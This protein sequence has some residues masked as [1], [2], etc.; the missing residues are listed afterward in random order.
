M[1]RTVLSRCALAVLLAVVGAAPLLL[2]LACVDERAVL[3]G[4]L[5]GGF[6]LA[7]A[8]LAADRFAC[9]EPRALLAQPGYLLGA[10][11]LLAALALGFLL[12]Q[13][14]L[15]RGWGDP[16]RELVEHLRPGQHLRFVD[17]LPV[18]SR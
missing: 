7:E 12:G 15:D 4:G 18:G 17:A 1:G 13:V 16:S 11:L 8:A 10:V 9:C 5:L 2:A 3:L 14:A 6:D